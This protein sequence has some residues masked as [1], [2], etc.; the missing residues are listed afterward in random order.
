MKPQPAPTQP[1]VAGFTLLELLVAIT[2]FA[3]M[4]VMAYGGLNHIIAASE[5]SQ[6]ALEQL[7]RLQKAVSLLDRDFSQLRQRDIRDEYGQ[8]QPWLKTAVDQDRLVEFTRGGRLNP[9]Q[10][11]RSSL[12]RVGYRLD[13]DR[14]LRLQWRDL[15][16]APGSEPRETTLLEGVDAVELRFLDQN[17]EWHDDW[18]PLA[19]ITT[20]A[21]GSSGNSLTLSAIE[22]RLSLTE[23]GEI[24][25]LYEVQ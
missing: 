17:G 22:F 16:R 21:D 2:V 20:N 8:R 25:R 7:Q 9:A 23:I 10:L 4:S 6:A 13:E 24:R 15:D 18:P 3:V 11:P 5:Q 19:G 1:K 14:L 12:V